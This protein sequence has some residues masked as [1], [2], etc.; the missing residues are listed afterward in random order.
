MQQT[1]SNF[2][3]LNL[4]CKRN[5]SQ[6]QI[7]FYF[8]FFREFGILTEPSK[9]IGKISWN[10]LWTNFLINSKIIYFN[11]FG[12]IIKTCGYSVKIVVRLIQILTF[13]KRLSATATQISNELWLELSYVTKI[14]FNQMK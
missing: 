8:L 10:S 6:D 4:F 5:E 7:N 12:G 14:T 2:Y 1:M 11:Y 9:L 3:I 13:Q